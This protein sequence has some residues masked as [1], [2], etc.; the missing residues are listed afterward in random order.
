MQMF[1]DIPC[2]FKKHSSMAF[3]N[4]FE[5][6]CLFVKSQ[7]IRFFNHSL[8]VC[9]YLV[10][11]D[12]RSRHLPFSECS[13]P[14]ATDCM[15]V[16]F[17]PR[18]QINIYLTPD[19]HR[20]FA[21]CVRYTERFQYMDNTCVRAESR[22][23]SVRDFLLLWC[24]QKYVPLGPVEPISVHTYGYK[25]ISTNEGKLTPHQLDVFHAL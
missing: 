22:I 19:Q 17:D 8:H 13:S 16:C 25:F 21:V 20:K 15:L 12:G 24:G 9:M 7:T 1:H 5:Y 6:F 18:L 4:F 11:L 10:K 14:S 3:Q 2:N 23:R